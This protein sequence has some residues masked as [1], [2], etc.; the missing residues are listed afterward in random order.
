MKFI[1]AL[2]K[3][4]ASAVTVVIAATTTTNI[5]F[6]ANATENRSQELN[7]NTYNVTAGDGIWESAA[8][9]DT[10][11]MNNRELDSFTFPSSV[12]NSTSVYFPTIGNQGEIGS[13]SGWSTTYYQYTYEVNKMLGI[14]TLQYN[15]ISE[16]HID[17]YFPEKD[18]KYFSMTGVLAKCS[19]KDN[20]ITILRFRK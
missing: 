16:N 11:C 20:I 5:S 17:P 18:A 1:K 14:S 2:K 3:T 19:N 12:D 7:T 4:V 6:F 13:C 10:I 8:N 15:E 9:S